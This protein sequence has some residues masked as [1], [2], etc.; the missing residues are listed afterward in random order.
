M[1]D[2]DNMS[3]VDSAEEQLA[4]NES[5][6]RDVNEAIESG[7]GE[8][9]GSCR[10]CGECGRLGCTDVVELTLREYEG[11]RAG[12]RCFLVAP[13]HDASFE[14]VV[15]EDAALHRRRQ[16][17]GP[18]RRHRRPDGSAQGERVS[19]GPAW[20]VAV[21]DDRGP[22]LGRRR[23]GD[24][25]AGAGVRRRAR[26]LEATGRRDRARGRRGGH[27]RRRARLRTARAG[28]VRV[29]VRLRGGRDR[30]R[31]RRRPGAGSRPPRPRGSG[32]GSRS[33]VPARRRSRSATARTAASEV[34]MRFALDAA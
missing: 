28:A 9:G 8:R 25:R 3:V 18:A 5:T 17:R 27:Q 31:G 4:L 29:E 23:R 1:A 21:P 22:R 24:P 19:A 2:D 12:S 26:R 20:A 34:W 30:G 16:A 13:G 7:R 32:S 6:F 11:V 10:S 15:R 14:R 33:S